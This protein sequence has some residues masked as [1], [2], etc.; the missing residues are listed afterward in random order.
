[1]LQLLGSVEEKRVLELGAGIGRFTADLARTAKTVHAVD[2]I[3]RFT[4]ANKVANAEHKNVSVEVT[5]AAV[6][7][8]PLCSL[9][10][11]TI[12]C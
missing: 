6:P 4:D 9:S 1:M 12:R 7:Q 8:P 10:I 11:A 2:F 3:Q 5:A